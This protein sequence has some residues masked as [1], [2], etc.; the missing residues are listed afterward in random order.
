MPLLFANIL[1]AF[2]ARG[3]IRQIVRHSCPAGMR[4]MSGRSRKLPLSRR[5]E[6]RSRRRPLCLERIFVLPNPRCSGRFARGTGRPFPG[7]DRPGG[8]SRTGL[9]AFLRGRSCSRAGCPR[10]ISARPRAGCAGLCAKPVGIHPCCPGTA[11]MDVAG[12][13]GTRAAHTGI[14]AG[15]EPR[16]GGRRRIDRAARRPK[17]AA[18]TALGTLSYL[19]TGIDAGIAADVVLAV[20]PPTFVP[21]TRYGSSPHRRQASAGC[22]PFPPPAFLSQLWRYCS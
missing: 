22:R 2:F 10:L 4:H 6:H 12:G 11:E 21:P 20:A 19:G 16:E 9:A 18:L 7:R 15:A 1:T 3:G 8:L 13:Y 17:M 14:A 5:Y